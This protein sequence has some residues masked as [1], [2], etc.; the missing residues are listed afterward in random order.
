MLDPAAGQ[1]SD[2][3]D[4]DRIRSAA[5]RRINRP[6]PQGPDAP[7]VHQRRRVE[8]SLLLRPSRDRS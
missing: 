5:P 8:L 1:I 6:A 7:R 3:V 2:A 4:E